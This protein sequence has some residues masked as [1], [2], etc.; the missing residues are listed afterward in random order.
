MQQ[1]AINSLAMYTSVAHAFCI[2][3]P[4][5]THHNTNELCDLTTYNRR[6]WC[7]CENFCHAVRHGCHGIWLATSPAACTKLFPEDR[8]TSVL[9]DSLEETPTSTVRIQARDFLLSNLR[10]FEA[11]CTVCDKPLGCANC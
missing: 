7:R 8:G 10:V 11:D 6:L 3:A 4:P 1:L 5:L 9:A 2:V